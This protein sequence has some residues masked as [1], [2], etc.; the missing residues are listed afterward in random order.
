MTIGYADAGALLERYRQALES[1]D[2][3][4]WVDLFTEDVEYHEDPFEPPLVGHNAIRAYLNE[5]AERLDQSELTIERH[6]VAG[7]TVL[8]AWHG[9]FIR[10][11]TRERVRLAGFLVAEVDESGRIARFREWWHHREGPPPGP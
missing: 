9:S 6:W 8:A 11:A 10:R 3:D 4:A 2:G 1:Y 7:S 5:A